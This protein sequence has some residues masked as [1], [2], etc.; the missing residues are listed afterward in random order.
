MWKQKWHIKITARG[1]R[2][3][4]IFRPCESLKSLV[5]GGIS[6]APGENTVE[7]ESS[8]AKREM[9]PVSATTAWNKKGSEQVKRL[10]SERSVERRSFSIHNSDSTNLRISQRLEHTSARKREA[11]D[12]Q[13][14]EGKK[15]RKKQE[16]RFPEFH[17]KTAV[18]AARGVSWVTRCRDFCDVPSR[19]LQDKCRRRGPAARDGKAAE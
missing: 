2:R 15:S 5:I 3:G 17:W 16:E 11:R 9:R 18:V 6:S 10:E 1:V 14:A 8:R 13:E 19:A 4:N 7:Q 12:R